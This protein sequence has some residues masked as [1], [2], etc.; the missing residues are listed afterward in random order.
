MFSL[1][2]LISASDFTVG[3]YKVKVSTQEGVEA[4]A[5]PELI[6]QLDAYSQFLNVLG[7]YIMY[8]DTD[9]EASYIK[10]IGVNGDNETILYKHIYEEET[11]PEVEQEPMVVPTEEGTET[12]EETPETVE[13]EVVNTTN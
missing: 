7:D 2:S 11:V 9:D 3:L 4:K 13:P 1:F 6:K 12:P 10:L 8:V 5:E